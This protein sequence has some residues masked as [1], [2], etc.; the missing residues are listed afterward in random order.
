MDPIEELANAMVKK[1]GGQV[2]GTLP[3]RNNNP[4][5]LRFAG[6]R[7]AVPGAGGFAAFPTWEDGFAALKRQI[8][9]D[10]SRGLTLQQFI[11]KF[12]PPS[13]NRSAEY[14]ASVSAWS[15]ISPDAVLRD[16]FAGHPPAAAAVAYT[17]P[18]TLD[19]VTPA[20]FLP[21]DVLA[22]GL[23]VDTAVKAASVALAFGVIWFSFFD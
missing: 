2:P 23:S 7:G 4:G 6:Q 22:G 19:Y 11:Y 1:E 16:V 17:A 15:G 18:G 21:A 10:A 12:A 8:A 9:L 3:Y 5:D 13:E 14:L 20:D